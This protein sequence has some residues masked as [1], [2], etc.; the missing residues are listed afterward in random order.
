MSNHY[1]FAG[2]EGCFVSRNSI[3]GNTYAIKSGAQRA[4]TARDHCAF[5]CSDNPA[6]ERPRDEQQ[7]HTW[8][9]KKPGTEQQPPNPAPGDP[10]FSPVLHAVSLIIVG[11]KVLIQVMVAS[12]D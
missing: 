7:I 6:D 10:E 3:S 5:Q 2:L 4:Q 9:Q 12:G 8:N 1:K 11:D